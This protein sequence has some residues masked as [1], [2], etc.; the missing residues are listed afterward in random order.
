M[1]PAQPVQRSACRRRPERTSVGRDVSTDR[2]G[3][4][5][6]DPFQIRAA[7][8]LDRDPVAAGPTWF[9]PWVGGE[10]GFAI[11]DARSRQADAHAVVVEELD[12]EPS[13]DEEPGLVRVKDA[14]FALFKV[15]DRAERRQ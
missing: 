15:L 2:T 12:D 5:L 6:N 10:L 14:A 7:P 1:E 13:V 3:R 8:E 4:Q 9:D 11:S